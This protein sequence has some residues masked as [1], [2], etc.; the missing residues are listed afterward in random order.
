MEDIQGMLEK[1]GDKRIKYFRNSDNLGHDLNIIRSF[2][3]AKGTYGFLLRARDGVVPD[4]IK[5]IIRI[6]KREQPVSYLTGEAID[7]EAKWKI[8]YSESK[9]IIERNECLKAH[10][11][12]YVHP[13]GSIYNI[14]LLDLDNIEQFLKENIET[15]FSFIAHN[16]FRSAL[17]IYGNFY[18]LKMP[19]WIYTNTEKSKD[20]AVNRM[21]NGFSVYSSELIIRRYNAECKW[22]KQIMANEADLLCYALIHLFKEYL[23][24]VTW[25]Q[26]RRNR[27][28]GIVAHYQI[29]PTKSN[30]RND[31]KKIYALLCEHMKD[32]SLNRE[33][34]LTVKKETKRIIFNNSTYGRFRYLMACLLDAM[35]IKPI[36]DTWRRKHENKY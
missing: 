36:F 21:S 23:Y 2:K 26:R 29:V 8:R 17:S 1:I 20:I 18:I 25:G 11:S 3:R 15:K 33:D 19:T 6:I 31:T 12:L 10:Y 34:F 14:K 9:M 4:S 7:E 22:I 24:Q 35:H 13:S 32:V 27:N 30:I 5:E 16:L 28:P